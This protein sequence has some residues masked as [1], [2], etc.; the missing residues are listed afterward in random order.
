MAAIAQPPFTELNTFGNILVAVQLA[1]R[2]EPEDIRKQ[3]LS[4]YKAAV[5]QSALIAKKHG[6]K[7]PVQVFKPDRTLDLEA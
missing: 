4:D 6:Q 1:I 5:A 2:D 3:L 7:E